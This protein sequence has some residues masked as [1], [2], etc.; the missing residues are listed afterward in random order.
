MSVS[1]VCG[2]IVAYTQQLF[3]HSVCDTMII[4]LVDLAVWLLGLQVRACSL[5]VY[6]ACRQM[7]SSMCVR[8]SR[9]TSPAA[10]GPFLL[11]RRTFS[12]HLWGAYSEMGSLR[13]GQCIG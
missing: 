2:T 10:S 1:Q 12:G 13:R 3:A 9:S 5:F 11:C 7:C 6:L 4:T 8:C